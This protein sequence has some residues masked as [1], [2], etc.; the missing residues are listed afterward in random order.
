MKKLLKKLTGFRHKEKRGAFIFKW[1][2]FN[3]KFGLELGVGS[4]DKE[5]PKDHAIF[6]FCLIFG[7][8][9]VNLWKGSAWKMGEDEIFE[10]YSFSVERDCW[11]IHLSWKGGY[12]I[13]SLPWA[14]DCVAHKV[15]TAEEKWVPYNGMYSEGPQYDDGRV[16]LTS[17]Y[18]YVL[19]NGKV[20][21]ARATYYVEK[22]VYKWHWF[23]WL[24]FKQNRKSIDV[25]FSKEI[26]ERTGSWKGGVLGTGHR[27]KK[28]ETPRQ[29]LV[30]M[31]KERKF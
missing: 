13:V 7:K 20:Q 5:D 2:E 30:R 6:Y 21:K 11:S 16:L 27:V 4:S 28:G 10:S 25:S 31:Q 23:K 12:K 18:I 17:P 15:L 26:G 22:F 3:P 9:T 24:P 8:V 29:T 19:K 1:G 14:W